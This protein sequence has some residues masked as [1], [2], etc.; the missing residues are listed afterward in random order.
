MRR[1]K[2]RKDR[3]RAWRSKGQRCRESLGLYSGRIGIRRNKSNWLNRKI[4]GEWMARNLCTELDNSLEREQQR[5][6]PTWGILWWK[7]RMRWLL[8]EKWSVITKVKN[9]LQDLLSKV[10]T[11]VTLTLKFL[12][13]LQQYFCFKKSNKHKPHQG[14]HEAMAAFYPLYSGGP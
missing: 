7:K 6:K 9:H 11:V 12:T 14:G 10:M 2:K 3:S 4:R 8:Q 1:A 5:K 13:E